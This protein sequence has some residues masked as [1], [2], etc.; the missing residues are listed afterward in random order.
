MNLLG[1][2]GVIESA[3]AYPA[4]RTLGRNQIVHVTHFSISDLKS[5]IKSPTNALSAVKT[6]MHASKSQIQIAIFHVPM[7]VRWACNH[8]PWLH[9]NNRREYWI[10][11][12]NRTRVLCT[13]TVSS[14]KTSTMFACQ[15]CHPMSSN[16]T[17]MTF[18][19]VRCA[20][21]GNFNQLKIY[22]NQWSWCVQSLC[23]ALSDPKGTT[24]TT[25]IDDFAIFNTKQ[26]DSVECERRKVFEKKNAEIIV[27][28]FVPQFHFY[29]HRTRQ[30]WKYSNPSR[31]GIGARL[32]AK[33]IAHQYLRPW[34]I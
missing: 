4:H 7:S 13:Q 27:A 12:V 14:V 16:R 5:T 30:S 34:F 21:V 19:S 15:M 23:G 29:G 33:A 1:D 9:Q 25:L 2:S 28:F 22:S 10:N 31:M 18:Y 26:Y 24:T 17:M 3:T 11:R 32:N 6:G 8:S 20:A